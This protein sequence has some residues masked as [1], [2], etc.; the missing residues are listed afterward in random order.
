[1][2][3]EGVEERVGRGKDAIQGI[4][5]REHVDALALGRQ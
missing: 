5:G 1:M 3:L 4:L 2:R